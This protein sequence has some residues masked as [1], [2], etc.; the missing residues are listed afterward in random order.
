[1]EDC[2]FCK[3][4]KNQATNWKIYENEKYMV[5]I[6]F[7]AHAWG[8]L[9][10]IPKKHYRWTSDVDDPEFWQLTNK[11]S[12]LIKKTY[13]SKFILGL[14]HGIGVPHAHNHL[15]PRFDGDGHGEVLDD[16]KVF[17]FSK[18]EKDKM[19]LELKSNL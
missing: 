11:M 13:N 3:I 6:P 4:A 9:L 17:R 19:L 12:K 18:E 2:T 8:H 10:V 16:E 15:I 1:M 5:I 14:Q 7:D